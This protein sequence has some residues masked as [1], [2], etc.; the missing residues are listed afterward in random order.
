[1]RPNQEKAVPGIPGRI[2]KRHYRAW[3]YGRSAGGFLSV[4]AALFLP[5][6]SRLI[7]GK[8]IKNAKNINDIK[9]KGDF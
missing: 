2:L 1:M 3:A 9:I 6:P 5:L 8:T 4:K 7:D